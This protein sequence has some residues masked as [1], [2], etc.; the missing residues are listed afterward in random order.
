MILPGLSVLMINMFR[1]PVEQS[2]A[3]NH[4]FFGRKF[5][6]RA[7]HHCVRA[8]RRKPNWDNRS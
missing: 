3:S 2:V 5:T 4:K 7:T 1:V 8:I 6:C